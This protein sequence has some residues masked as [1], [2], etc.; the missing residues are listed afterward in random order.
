MRKFFNSFSFLSVI[1]TMWMNFANAQVSISVSPN[2]TPSTQVPKGVWVEVGRY[3]LSS[4]VDTLLTDIEVRRFGG[5]GANTDIERICFVNT[6]HQKI[7]A[8]QA[9]GSDGAVFLL[10]DNFMLEANT[11]QEILLMVKFSDSSSTVTQHAF[12]VFGMNGFTWSL[13][14]VGCSLTTN[15]MTTTNYIPGLMSVNALNSLTPLPVQTGVFEEFGRFVVSV[16]SITT[17]RGFN[18]FINNFLVV[19]DSIGVYTTTGEL[20]SHNYGQTGPALSFMFDST[21]VLN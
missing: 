19:F 6:R 8:M 15:V 16:D 7:S 10:L 3:Q 1:V 13:L 14:C 21:L 18:V 20:I 11:P 4:T 5:L 9:P 17:I 12:E 2:T